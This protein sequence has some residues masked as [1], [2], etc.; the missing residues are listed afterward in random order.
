VTHFSHDYT[1]VYQNSGGG[2]FTDASYTTGVAVGAGR[3]M[4]WGVGFVDFDNSGLLDL[5]VA[6]GHLYPEVYSHGLGT[7][8]LQRK[9]LFH[10][11]GNKRF[12]DVTEQAGKGLLIEKSSRGA[13]FG[14]YDNDGDLDV[15]VIN[16]NDRPTLLRNDTPHANHWVTIELAGTKGNRDAIGARVRVTAGGRTRVSEVRSGGSYLSQND[17]RVHVGLGTADRVEQVQIRWPG[18][19]VETARDLQADRFYVAREGQ[20][21]RPIVLR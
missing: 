16:L 8:Y 12:Q 11:L 13:A 2:L 18:G 6:N 9:Q 1:T 17:R 19:A 10:N 15:L 20:G 7:R 4:G 3:Y 14:D 21:I 5:F